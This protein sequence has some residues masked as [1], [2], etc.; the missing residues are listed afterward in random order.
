MTPMTPVIADTVVAV[1][2][3]LAASIIVKATAAAGIALLGVRLARNSRAS[4]HHLVFVAAFRLRH[5]Q[6]GSPDSI[7][8]LPV[9]FVSIRIGDVTNG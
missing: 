9:E 6:R 8:T 3:S 1:G 2:E 4:V 5:R 7:D